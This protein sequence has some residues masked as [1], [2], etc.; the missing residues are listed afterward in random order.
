[1]PKAHVVDLQNSLENSFNEIL[2]KTLKEKTL[3]RFQGNE[4]EAKKLDKVEKEIRA[5]MQEARDMVFA[6]KLSDDNVDR[7]VADLQD[8]ADAARNS[9]ENLRKTK[10]FLDDLVKAAEVA[11]GIVKTIKLVVAL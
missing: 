3:L 4:A 1:M 10:D 8:D 5:K 9:L 7:L 6:M 11:T 2:K